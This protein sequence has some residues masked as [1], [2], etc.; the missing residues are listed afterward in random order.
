MSPQT[1]LEIVRSLSLWPVFGDRFLN[2]ALGVGW[3]LSFELIF[4]LAFATALATRPAI[5]LV[6]YALCLA[7]GFWSSHILFWFLG[8]PLVFE[9]LL[10]VAIARLP[11]IPTLGIA[12]VCA[13]LLS[14]ALAPATYYDQAFG[15]GALY[16]A[17]LWGLPAA[18]IVYGTRSLEDW[19]GGRAFGL[20]FLLG[21]ASYSIYLFHPLVFLRFKGPAGFFLSAIAGIAMYLVVERQIMRA[22]PKWG[23]RQP[24]AAPQ[25]AAS[26]PLGT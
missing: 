3:T 11:Q 6:L 15:S 10:G 21:C 8:S 4:Y 25:T 26:V 5:P 9:F 24:P 18:M 23:R 12:M 19:F 14:F 7:A 13:G 16:R 22:R 1:P 17:L 20:L 2:P